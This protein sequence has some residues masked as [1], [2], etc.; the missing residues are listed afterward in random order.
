MKAMLRKNGK[1]FRI[2]ITKDEFDRT[3][4][5]KI[6]INCRKFELKSNLIEQSH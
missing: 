1:L 6:N 2:D 5:R 4:M 3:Y